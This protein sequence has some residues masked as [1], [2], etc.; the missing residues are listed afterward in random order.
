MIDHKQLTNAMSKLLKFVK[1][2]QKPANSFSL[3][4][5]AE[6]SAY[7]LCFAIYNFHLLKESQVIQDNA[8]EWNQQLRDGLL[9]QKKARE[10]VGILK[11]DKP[12]LQ[13]LTFTLSAL[14]ILGTLEQDPLEEVIKPLLPTDIESVF[15]KISCLEGKAQSGNQ[16]MFIAIL[17]QFANDFLG[18]NTT[19]DINDWQELHTR[20][21]NEFG[22]WG[23]F[24]SMS[25]LQFQN[26]YHQYELLE[27]FGNHNA[28]WAKAAASVASLIDSDGHFAPYPGGGGCYDYDA[29][30]MLTSNPEI[31]KK[32]ESLL[33]L[34]ANTL[35]KEQNRDGGFCES[36]YVRPRSIVNISK[37]IHH[38]FSTSKLARVER[39]KYC[40]TLM[41][42][43]HDRIHTHWSK[44]SR[45]WHESDLWD[46]WFRMLT[47]ARIDCAL[48]PE[49]AK[50]WGFINFPGIGFHPSL[51][52]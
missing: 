50:N 32:Y 25:H 47:I 35:L 16:A 44:Y 31:S 1:T 9:K 24:K 45:H 46:S 34:T 48:N 3:T 20:N 27:Y 18:M 38:I 13:L 12:Y 4:P 5:N 41:R 36:H 40:L 7:A 10:Q 6:P 17:L 19:K 21:T 22:F 15:K 28:P 43:K 26:G 49:H 8:L 42:P 23:Q 2:C 37:S 52:K 14:A 11:T 39:L 30:F 33:H 51:C 29:V